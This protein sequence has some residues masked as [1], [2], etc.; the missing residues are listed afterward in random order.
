MWVGTVVAA[1]A[2]IVPAVLWFFERRDR[3]KAQAEADDLRTQERAAAERRSEQEAEERRVAQARKV[4]LM[5]TPKGQITA[6]NR[7]DL[8]IYGLSLVT[9]KTAEPPFHARLAAPVESIEGL[10]PGQ[11]WETTTAPMP[12]EL[13][14]R[15]MDAAGE[16]WLRDIRGELLTVHEMLRRWKSSTH[17]A[18]ELLL[19]PE[20]SPGS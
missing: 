20:G 5:R 9:I 4:A 14:L 12:Q 13:W 6:Y 18:A 11:V 8:P 3:K 15:F 1:A 19:K 17:A 7:S 10:A 2:A 16:M